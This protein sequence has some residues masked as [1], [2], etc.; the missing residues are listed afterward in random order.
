MKNGQSR[1][2]KLNRCAAIFVFYI[3]LA[4]S[5]FVS[6]QEYKGGATKAL[7]NLQNVK[8]K[9]LTE[10]LNS[11][12]RMK[13]VH[14][15]IRDSV[16]GLDLELTGWHRKCYQSFTKNLDCLKFSIIIVYQGFKVDLKGSQLLQ[17]S[18]Y[19]KT[20]LFFAVRI[21]LKSKKMEQKRKSWQ[22]NIL[23]HGYTNAQVGKK[24]SCHG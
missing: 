14:D 15:F 13:E 9:K 19:P 24:Y 17:H 3:T 20:S 16:D 21:G 6:L 7:E 22:I 5:I 23:V 1:D 2:Q 4:F 10:D 12:H 8:E 18:H 11:D